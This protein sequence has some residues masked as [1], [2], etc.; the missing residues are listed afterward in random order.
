MLSVYMANIARRRRCCHCI[1]RIEVPQY[2]G[3]IAFDHVD[4]FAVIVD[5]DYSGSEDQIRNS[6]QYYISIISKMHS[7]LY[8]I[9]DYSSL[10]YR[11]R[12]IRQAK[13]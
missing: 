1:I 10:G 9:L 11:T 13:N 6:Y 8:L 2:A 7:G 3:V 5:S 12:T 4:N